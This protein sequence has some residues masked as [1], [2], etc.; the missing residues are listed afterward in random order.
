MGASE[1]EKTQFL[2]HHA[3]NFDLELQQAGYQNEQL[4]E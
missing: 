2:N 3:S 4:V 1:R